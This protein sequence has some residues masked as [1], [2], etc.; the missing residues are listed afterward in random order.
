MIKATTT[1][2]LLLASLSVH[3]AKPPETPSWTDAATAAKDVEH[4][5]TIGEYVA[6]DGKTAIQANL[7]SDGEFL[8]A[9][10]QGGLPGDGWDLSK[11]DSKKMPAMALKEL[12]ASYS[13]VERESPTLGK[14]AP[15][16]AIIK[17]PD[18]LTNVADG[19]M[20]AGGKTAK[21][22]GSFHMHLEF[23]LPLKPGHNP[24]SQKR[25]NSG[26]YIFNNYE[27][28]V[29]DTFGLDYNNPENNAIKPESLNKQ[30]CGSFYKQ[31]L[32]DVN[33]TYPPLRWQ[34]YD[35]DFT[36]PVLDGGKKVKNARITVRHNG[37]LIHDD[38]ELLTGTG[39]GA[40]KPQLAEG[41]VFFQAHGNP[42]VYRNVWATEL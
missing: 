22:L 4:F 9:L 23:L 18:D 3:A 11:I 5:D 30:W 41:P 37:V 38:F 13:K 12:L 27:I 6:K 25:G 42:V 15:A 31:K 19:I 17:F 34:T 36:A 20:Q 28:Q 2:L 33:M 16:N 14:P 8:V 40:K 7:L 21:D 24:S 29:I 39:N 32:P 1:L 35:I 10:Y 26:I